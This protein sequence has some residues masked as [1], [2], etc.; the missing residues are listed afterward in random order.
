MESQR[1]ARELRGL[2]GPAA[3]TAHAQCAALPVGAKACG[4][5][6][7]YWAWAPQAPNADRIQ[8]VAQRLADAQR[9]ENEASGLRSNCAI[10][11]PPSAVCTAG[12]CELQTTPASAL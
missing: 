3:C 4:G 7:G 1:L 5:P 9:R 8:A 11:P 10:A 6:A 12:R 2:I